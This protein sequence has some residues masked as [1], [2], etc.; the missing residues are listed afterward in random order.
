MNP[1]ILKGIRENLRLK[2]L[3]AAGLF[4]L[5]ICSTVYLTAFLEGSD[6]KNKYDIVG[7]F[8]SYVYLPC[9]PYTNSLNH[10]HDCECAPRILLSRFNIRTFASAVL[11][12]SFQHYKLKT[13]LIFK[14]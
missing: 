12:L 4:S 13:F 5:I 9:P 6:G 1:L 8:Y 7:N 11:L 3:I 10:C 2:H 14:S